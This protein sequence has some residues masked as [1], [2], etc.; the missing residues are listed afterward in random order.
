M[1]LADVLRIVGYVLLA[2][3]YLI[4]LITLIKPWY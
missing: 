2:T 1:M 4:N 3:A